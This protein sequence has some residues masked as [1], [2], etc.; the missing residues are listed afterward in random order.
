M[1]KLV[2]NDIRATIGNI[3]TLAIAENPRRRGLIIGAPLGSG[4]GPVNG[5]NGGHNVSTAAT[6]VAL[7]YT[8]PAGK[9]AVLGFASAVLTAGTAP[10]IQLQSTDGGAT[11]I[12]ILASNANIYQNLNVTLAAGQTVQ[13][14][15]TTAG[16]LSTM[17]LLITSVEYGVP[18][19]V[20]MRFGN[21]AV[22]DQ[23]M[24]LYGDSKPFE[25]MHDEFH[26]G[27]EQELHM[28]SQAANTL[29]PI[30]EYLWVTCDDGKY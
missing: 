21:P 19:R 28:I 23:D 2:R 4:A 11:E 17:D 8:V 16:A 20:S 6:G 7:S 26:W 5:G 15:V 9:Y 22:L 25:I 12:A 3:D 27:L 10:T 30:W 29:V 18:S 1:G 14:N 24:T 13:W